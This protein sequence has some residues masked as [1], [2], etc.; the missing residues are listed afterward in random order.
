MLFKNA[1]SDLL[2]RNLKSGLEKW[3]FDQ[4]GTLKV[5]WATT[6][7]QSLPLESREGI[8][9]PEVTAANPTLSN[10]TF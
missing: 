1:K 9:V 6:S 3:L 10:F 5:T 8:G 2:G 7:G 4:R